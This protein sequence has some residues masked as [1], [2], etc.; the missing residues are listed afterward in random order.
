MSF[1]QYITWLKREKSN[2]LSATP[3]FWRKLLMSQD[4]L[5]LPINRITLGG[6]IVGLLFY[7][8]L[9][10]LI[11]VRVLPIF[12]PQKKLVLACPS[13]MAKLASLRNI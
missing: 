4:G 2:A 12:M 5:Q 1:D 3:T 10:E 13:F 6:E 7:E 9:S 8:R 11:Q